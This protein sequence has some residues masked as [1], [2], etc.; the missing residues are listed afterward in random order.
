MAEVKHQEPEWAFGL[1]QPDTVKEAFKTE[2]LPGLLLTLKHKLSVSTLPGSYY[3]T[4]RVETRGPG[5]KVDYPEDFGPYTGCKG[6]AVSSGALIELTEDQWK[7]NNG[8]ETRVVLVPHTRNDGISDIG[9]VPKPEHYAKEARPA[10]QVVRNGVVIPKEA[11]PEID[12]ESEIRRLI[13][14]RFI[15]EFKKQQE[16]KAAI[17]KARRDYPKWLQDSLRPEAEGL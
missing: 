11:V 14:R 10:C 7:L 12:G 2:T 6:R 5:A 3:K 1:G 9:S 16:V 13:K 17:E 15:G 4:S 8:K